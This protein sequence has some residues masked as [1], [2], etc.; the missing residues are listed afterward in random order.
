[1]DIGSKIEIP[2][3]TDDKGWK[4]LTKLIAETKYFSVCECGC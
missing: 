2:K 3:K 1:V 4:K